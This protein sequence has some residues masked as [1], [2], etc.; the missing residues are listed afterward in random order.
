MKA[1]L[2]TGVLLLGSPPVAVAQLPITVETL[3]LRFRSPKGW[4][5][6][7]ESNPEQLVLAPGKEKLAPLL[8]VQLFRGHQPAKDRIAQMTQGLAGEEALVT[9]HGAEAWSE[10]GVN[11]ETVSAVYRKGS[12]EWWA[13]FTLVDQPEKLQ[14]GFWLFGRKQDL[15]RQRK[16]VRTSIRSAL[17]GAS[18]AEVAAEEP[19]TKKQKT[20]E[21]APVATPADWSD[22]KSGLKVASWPAGYAPVKSSLTKLSTTGLVFTPSTSGAPAGAELRLSRRSVS[23][24]VSPRSTADTLEERL[25]EAGARRVERDEVAIDGTRCIRLR[26]LQEVRGI[27]QRYEVWVWKAGTSLYRLDGSAPSDWADAR[28]RRDVARN[29]IQGLT[30]P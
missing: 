15:K 8:R 20:E 27:D 5:L 30:F 22:A 11:F 9:F 12:Q 26:W 6:L 4:R 25:E 24:L 18:G 17:R 14:H 21:A 29:F 13:E 28:S 2:L 23:G 1:L 19:R 16:A 10:G 7:P 3:D